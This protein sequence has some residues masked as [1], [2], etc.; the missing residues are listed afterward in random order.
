MVLPAEVGAA[1]QFVLFWPLIPV[2]T[3]FFPSD[4]MPGNERHSSCH[5]YNS[6][7]PLLS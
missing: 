5:G 7:M 4:R 2:Y 1:D 3:M 6:V